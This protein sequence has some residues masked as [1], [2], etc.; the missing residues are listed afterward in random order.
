MKALR[1]KRRSSAYFLG[2]CISLNPQ[3]S[4]NCNP[5]IKQVEICEVP[6]ASA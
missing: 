5:Y 3:L 1:S 2:S 6:D 4:Y